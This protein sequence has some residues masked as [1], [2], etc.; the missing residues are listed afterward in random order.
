MTLPDSSRAGVLVLLLL[1]VLSGCMNTEEAVRKRRERDAARVQNAMDGLVDLQIAASATGVKSVQLYPILQGE[2]KEAWLPVI[3]GGSDALALEFDLMASSGRPL[4]AY[5]Y[6]A[7]REWNRD[8]SPPE[9]LGSF[10]HDDLIDYTP[11]RTTD[12]KYVHYTYRF[13]NTGIDFRLSGN[14]ILRVTEQG[15]EDAVLFERPFFIQERPQAVDGI[16]LESVMMGGGGYPG[17]MPIVRFT[18]PSDLQGSPYDYTV[19]FVRNGRYERAR[20]T[21]RPSLAVQPS[22]QFDLVPEF[23][24]QA[25]PPAFF[26]DLGTFMEGGN[27]EDADLSVIPTR[28]L[29]EPDYARFPGTPLAP[30]LN[31]QSVISTAARGVADA[32]VYG[33]YAEVVFSFVPPDETP[34][35]GDLFVV[36]SF[37]DWRIDRANRLRWVSERGRYE[38]AVLLKQGWYEYRYD[39]SDRALRQVL[40]TAPPRMGNEYTA[41]VYYN[42]LSRSTDR[43][44][45]VQGAREN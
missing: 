8:L 5:F 24:F 11:S 20:C 4:T 18:P 33:D 3:S 2:A 19:C 32:D 28:I 36:G 17:T 23:A 25:E 27:I 21:D 16:G 29:L 37:S 35:R 45:S 39:S 44:I 6:H 1:L 9:Y 40:N 31:G 43:L 38:G 15:Q 26:L 14:Y 13:P 42:D 34:I 10:F 12:V 30:M 22:L 7:D 41:F